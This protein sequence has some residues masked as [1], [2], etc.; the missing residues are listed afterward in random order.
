MTAYRMAQSLGNTG[1]GLFHSKGTWGC[2]ALKGIL[3]QTSSLAKGML[4]GNFGPGQSRQG[5]NF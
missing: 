5:Y 4:F 3:F 2:A 1:E